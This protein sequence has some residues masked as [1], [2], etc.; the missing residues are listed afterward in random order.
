MLCLF[1][2][3]VRIKLVEAIDH[4]DE[5]ERSLKKSKKKNAK[6]KKKPLR[7]RRWFGEAEHEEDIVEEVPVVEEAPHEVSKKI[8][9]VRTENLIHEPFE[10]S[11]EIK[12]RGATLPPALASQ[13]FHQYSWN[14]V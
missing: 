2:P 4:E 5:L 14:R 1:Q 12:V 6:K 7:T 10:Q 3:T 8:R 13:C 11:Q 9:M